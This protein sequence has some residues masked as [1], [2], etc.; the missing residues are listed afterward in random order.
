MP[1]AATEYL[2]INPISSRMDFQYALLDGELNLLDLQEASREDLA[3]LL[4]G[5]PSLLVA[6]NSPSGVNQGVVKAMLATGNPDPGHQFRGVDIRLAE[7]QLRQRGI[8]LSGTPAQE[9]ACPSWMRMGFELYRQLSES[10]F[11]PFPARASARQWVESHPFAGFCALLEQ[12]PFPGQT[13][14]GRLQ[15][16]L[17]L[18]EK[19]MRIADPMGFFEE[20]TRFKLLNGILPLD[21]IY[22]SDQLD[23]LAA[24]F[25]AWVA[26]NQPEGLSLVGDEREGRIALPAGRLKKT[27]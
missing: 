20:I 16:Q 14:E 24:A 19:G 17:V 27:Y 26:G 2:G 10:G 4:S 6:V 15:R 5:R 3:E 7:Y 9:E 23:V 25:T 12:M 18:H 22:R 21:T 13:L 11:Q 1:P 8:G